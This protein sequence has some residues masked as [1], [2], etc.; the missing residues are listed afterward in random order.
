MYDSKQHLQYTF[1]T[2]TPYD[3]VYAKT[4]ACDPPMCGG[5]VGVA[6]VGVCMCVGVCT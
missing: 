1:P 3:F 5:G 4:N 6:L 2:F